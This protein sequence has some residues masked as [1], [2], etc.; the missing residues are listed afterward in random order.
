MLVSVYAHTALQD[1]EAVVL[2]V[3]MTGEKWTLTVGGNGALAAGETDSQHSTGVTVCGVSLTHLQWDSGHLC[4]RQ[5]S[6][7]SSMSLSSSKDDDL[8]FNSSQ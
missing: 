1:K 2:C 4:H 3:L 8:Y 6:K 7:L 5:T